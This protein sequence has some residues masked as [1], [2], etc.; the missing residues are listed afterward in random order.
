MRIVLFIH[1][2]NGGGA[3][4]IASLMAGYW[5]QKGHSVTVLTIASIDDNRYVLPEKVALRALCIDGDSKNLLAAVYNNISRL[6]ILR[7]TFREIQPDIVIS[8]MAQANVMA[9]LACIGLTI[10]SIG[11]ER[12][13]P[14]M[15]YTGRL[16]GILRKFTYCFLD[17]VVTQTYTSEKWISDFTNSNRVLTIPNPL[18]LPLA[19]LDP[20]VEPKKPDG[21]KLLL[22]VGRLNKQKQ[23]SHLIE[24][25]ACLAEKYSDWNLV[26][27][28]EG[29]EEES[30]TQ[31]ISKYSLAERARLIGRVGNMDQVRL[32]KM[33]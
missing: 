20:V 23:F 3:E 2:L 17:V 26:I 11:A 33:A 15:D 22:G 12:H 30:L 16:W 10:K 7:R 21:T 9:G 1:S 31:M 13:Y 24:C 5:A 6:K 28:G 19:K 14:G 8:M 29:V 18:E 27:V 4:R 25:F 32:L